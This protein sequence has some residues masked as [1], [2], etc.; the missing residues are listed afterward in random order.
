[1]VDVRTALRQPDREALVRAVA[2]DV[3]INNAGLRRLRN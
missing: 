3:L 2:A 1:V